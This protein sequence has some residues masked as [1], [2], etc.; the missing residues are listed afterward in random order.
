MGLFSSLMKKKLRCHK[1]GKVVFLPRLKPQSLIASSTDDRVYKKDRALE[2]A[3]CGKPTCNACARKAA[4]SIGE[5][6]PI[7]PSCSGSLR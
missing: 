7:C 1:C 3:K 5:S 6:K 4:E 2:C